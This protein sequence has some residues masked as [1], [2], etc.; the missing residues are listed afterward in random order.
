[1]NE[2]IQFITKLAAQYKIYAER[3]EELFAALNALSE[4][5]VREIYGEYGDGE[6]FQ[7]VNV[8]RSEIARLLLEGVE[9][10]KDKVEEIKERIREKDADYFRH[11]SAD[12]SAQM[13]DYA[14]GKRDMF[15]N[16]QKDWN[17]FHTFFIAEK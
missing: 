12:L 1:M 5:S 10:S 6:R 8:L 4:T 14:V 16:R 17:V 2:Q 11:L 15:A 7:P 3:K 13:N 9:I